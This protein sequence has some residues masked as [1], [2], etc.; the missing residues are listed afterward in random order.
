MLAKALRFSDR[1]I[2]DALLQI[3]SV[4]EL[5]A[6]ADLPAYRV[7][8]QALFDM[9]LAAACLLPADI[10][11]IPDM[12]SPSPCLADR[13]E[14]F[15][16]QAPSRGICILL[17]ARKL[18]VILPWATHLALIENGNLLDLGPADIAAEHLDILGAATGTADRDDGIDDD[19]SLDEDPDE[20][21]NGNRDPNYADAA[22]TCA[23][24]REPGS[25]RI[26]QSITRGRPVPPL[27]ARPSG[28]CG[29]SAAADPCRCP[30]T[31]SKRGLNWTSP[32]THPA[33]GP[34]WKSSQRK[35]F[36]PFSHAVRN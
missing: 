18:S 11:A 14:R 15:V 9:A 6:I 29:K 27:C 3:R 23:E 4:R 5:D 33:S 34:A 13:W 10:V 7:P 19:G 17:A 20:E 28:R 32:K 35:R 12:R 30:S 22:F 26:S 1:D 21:A 25:L 36:R 16:Q 8:K 24:V 31:I 2:S